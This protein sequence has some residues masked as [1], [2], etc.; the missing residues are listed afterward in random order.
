MM[1]KYILP[2]E[3]IHKFLIQYICALVINKKKYILSSSWPKKSAHHSIWSVQSL[4]MQSHDYLVLLNIKKKLMLHPYSL[5]QYSEVHHN[6]Y[7]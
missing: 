5:P 1:L 2:D 6:L 3:S 7:Y 4:P